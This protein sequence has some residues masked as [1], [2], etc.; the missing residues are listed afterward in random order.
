MSRE[1]EE[2]ADSL[3]TTEAVVDYLINIEDMSRDAVY[4]MIAW[5][6]PSPAMIKKILLN[7]V[8]EDGYFFW[9]DVEYSR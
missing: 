1:N 6:E 5:G 9:G 8:I 2:F 3:N 7:A 4:E